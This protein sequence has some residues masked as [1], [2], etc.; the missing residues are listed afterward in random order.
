MCSSFKL[1]LVAMVLSQQ[2]HGGLSLTERLRYGRGDLQPHSPVTG[3]RVGQGSM[4]VAELSAATL[5]TSDNT[6]ANLLLARL[7]GP[8]ALTRFMRALGD[9]ETRLDRYEP[10][11]NAAGDH[12]DWDTS[13][14]T[15]M[16]HSLQRL[17]LGDALP[18][19]QRQQLITWLQASSTGGQRLKAGLPAAWRIAEKTGT[20][21]G[22]TNDIGVVWPAQGSALVAVAF[23]RDSKAAFA[24]R[25]ACLAEL[26][27][28]LT[29][30]PIQPG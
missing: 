7:G 28:I 23:I 22:S 13:T 19:P 3:A 17:L 14:P 27:Q 18:P 5:A 16:A 8:A 12:P 30:A 1:L 6:A 21:Q 11:L 20:S 4:T 26:G 2:A 9:D 15:A 10:H 29:L 25:E 24:V